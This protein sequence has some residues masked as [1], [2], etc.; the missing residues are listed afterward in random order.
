MTLSLETLELLQHCL[1]AQQ[2]NVGA[3]DFDDVATKVLAARRELADAIAQ[4][5]DAP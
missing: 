4:H 3:P 5:Q 1:N 2:L